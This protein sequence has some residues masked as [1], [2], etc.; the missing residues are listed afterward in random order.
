MRLVKPSIHFEKSHRSFIEEMVARNEE[1]IPWV[2]A[3]VGDDFESYVSW[4]ERNSEG[5][6]LP[7]GFVASTT[8]W[9]VDG[10]E[11]IVAV[12]N[13][14]HEL[15]ASLLDYGGH[16]G[17]GVRPSARRHGY[18]TEVLKQTVAQARKLGIGDVLVTCD[19]E[20]MGSAKAIMSNGGELWDERYMK[21]HSCTLQRYWIRAQ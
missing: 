20:N 10:A 4:L 14:R 6:G 1:L 3:E 12:S 17:F 2:L 7:S 11:E 18:A 8:F 21:Q 16:I 9:L 13:L 5:V 15:T 19:R